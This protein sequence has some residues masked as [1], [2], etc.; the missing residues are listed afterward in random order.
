MKK[1]LMIGMMCLPLTMMAQT[2][3][4]KSQ[5]DRVA[6]LQAEAAAKAK[7]AQEAAEAAQKAAREAQEAAEKAAIEARKAEQAELE[8]TKKA[9]QEAKKAEEARK[10][11]EAKKAEEVKK[12]EEAKKAEET[13]KAE[14]AKDTW[15]APATNNEWVVPE[16]KKKETTNVTQKQAKAKEKA[17]KLEKNAPYLVDNAVPVI[18]G[19]VQWTHHIS[20]PGKSAKQLYDAMFT[21]LDNM[22]H[23]GNQLERS[24]VAIVN[25]KQHSIAATFQEWLVFSQNFISLD[26]TKLSYVLQVNCTDGNVDVIMS[27]VSYI[28]EVAGKPE[29]YKAEEWITDKYAVNK[30]HTKL[31]PISGKFRRKTIDRKN[32]VFKNMEEAVK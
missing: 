7:A 13:K 26:R 19:E 28:Y 29:N 15:T 16:T 22:T 9:Q 11:A 12:A 30:K 5:T 32:E 3:I 17:E 20:A 14:E 23:E 1:I 27:R 4:T 6:E 24:K 2:E 25:E 31:L 21:F 18:D 10:A 8:Q